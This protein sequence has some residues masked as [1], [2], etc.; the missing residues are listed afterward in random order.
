MKNNIIIKILCSI[1]VILFFL[2]YCLFIGILLIMLRYYVYYKRKDVSFLLIIMGILLYIPLILSKFKINISFLNNNYYLELLKLAKRLIIVGIIFMIIYF[3]AN[4]LKLSLI[5]Y[6]KNEEE[7]DNKIKAKNDLIM[8]EKR[9]K[10]KNTRVVKC[11]YCGADNILSTNVGKCSYC[12]K[13]LK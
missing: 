10:A 8:Q 2:Y 13:Q 4:K 12:R 1:P 11:P 7:N 3:V 5:N 9:E 6:I